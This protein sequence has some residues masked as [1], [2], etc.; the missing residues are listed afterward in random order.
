MT[1]IIYCL[2]RCGTMFWILQS[3]KFP[4]AIMPGAASVWNLL[5]GGQEHVHEAG[6][7]ANHA[8]AESPL[9]CPPRMAHAPLS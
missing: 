7:R 1:D 4:T 8:Q 6:K 5:L 3:L 9:K 2:R